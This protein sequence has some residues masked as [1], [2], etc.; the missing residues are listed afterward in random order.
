MPQQGRWSAN[1][2]R[3]FIVTLRGGG[4]KFVSSLD[5]VGEAGSKVFAQTGNDGRSQAELTGG[6]RD[7][8][9]ASIKPA[10]YAS[11]CAPD[12]IVSQAMPNPQQMS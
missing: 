10:R 12:Q 4:G 8:Q 1:V 7:K 3:L 9:T 2:A 11:D 6:W 5:E